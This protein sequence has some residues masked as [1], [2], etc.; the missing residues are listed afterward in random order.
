[1]PSID[2]KI[3]DFRQRLCFTSDILGILV[4]TG[5]LVWIYVMLACFNIINR[6]KGYIEL[7]LGLAIVLTLLIATPVYNEFR[8]AYSLY[9]MMPLVF[10]I[11]VKKE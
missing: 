10:Y 3:L 11:A 2:E 4:S 7:T 9:T 8:Y 5:F 6:Q 1:M